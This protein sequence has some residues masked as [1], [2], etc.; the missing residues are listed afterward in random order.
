M[1]S[2]IANLLFAVLILTACVA[3]TPE[4][5][6]TA[7][8]VEIAAAEIRVTETLPPVATD[9]SSPTAS[10]APK[11]ETVEPAAEA[12]SE[13]AELAAPAE[14]PTLT[15]LPMPT[16]ELVPLV[17]SGQIDDGAFFLG[18]PNAPLTIIDY[19]DFL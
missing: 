4:V 12:P 6:D 7:A 19:S 1:K 18:D 5:V 9:E 17:I 16:D 11:A 15:P 14:P 3:N 8:Q 13:E 2:L 10:S